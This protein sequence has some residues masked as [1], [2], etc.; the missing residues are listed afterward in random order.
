MYTN[1]GNYI[2]MELMIT[3]AELMIKTA[4]LSIKTAEL[5]LIPRFRTL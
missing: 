3:T 2:F 5:T 1:L 4:E